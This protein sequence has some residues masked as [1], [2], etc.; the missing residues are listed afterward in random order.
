MQPTKFAKLLKFVAPLA[1]GALVGGF[2]GNWRVPGSGFQAEQQVQERNRQFG[3]QQQE[4]GLRRDMLQRQYAA[5]QYRNAL[6]AARTKQADAMADRYAQLAEGQ[7]RT[8]PQIEDTDAGLMSVDPE[9]AQARPIT[10]MAPEETGSLPLPGESQV[11]PLHKTQRAMAPERPVV[12]GEGQELVQPSTGKIVTPPRPKTFAPRAPRA[13]DAKNATQGKA[14]TYADALVKQFG[15]D[16]DKALAA[17]EDL[18]SLD[19]AMKAEVRKL[20]RDIK[21]PATGRKLPAISPDQMKRLAQ[22]PPA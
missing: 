21:K 3:L 4:L 12:V 7:V 20:I 17:V 22:A 8:K 1:Q 16:A 14:E 19:P 9:T 15:G 10:N 11:A 13:A 18:K 2:G 6:E 5:D